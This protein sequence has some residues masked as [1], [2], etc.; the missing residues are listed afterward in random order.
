VGTAT[1]E[2]QSPFSPAFTDRIFLAFGA[3]NYD[4][5]YNVRFS[6]SEEQKEVLEKI[7][8]QNS[9]DD[10]I[11]KAE[12]IVERSHLRL[13]RINRIIYDDPSPGIM[14]VADDM[15]R[16]ETL[17]MH[18]APAFSGLDLNP[19]EISISGNIMMEWIIE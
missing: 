10:A 18:E 6:L 3:V 4:I 14:Y 11:S 8:I 17:S 16:H 7:V 12:T 13:V 19:K 1:L 2:I 9:I 15:A 5:S